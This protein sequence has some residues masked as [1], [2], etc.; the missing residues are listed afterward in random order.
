MNCSVTWIELGNPYPLDRPKRYSPVGWPSGSILPLPTPAALPEAPFPSVARSRRTRREFGP[1][2]LGSLSGL[3]ELTCRVQ[4][5]GT[6]ELG[7]PISK[8]GVA[9]SGAIHPVHVVVDM[10]QLKAWHRYD[11]QHHALVSLDTHVDRSE[12]REGLRDVVFAP[13]ATLLLM[14]G[15][16][17]MAAAKY[18]DPTSLVW[19]DAGVLLG[20]LSLAAEA[21]G[22]S[23]CP[24][25]VTG[26][27]WAREFVPQPGLVGLGGAFLGR[28][29][30]SGSE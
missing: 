7:F 4:L 22:L 28:K 19:R 25:G 21:F 15:E 27:P 2:D 12:V 30:G 14:V 11:P 6:D 8:R 10:P 17:G 29:P 18:G 26:D 20:C 16:P 3:M 1:L 13:T 9:S 23:F 5:L 24:L